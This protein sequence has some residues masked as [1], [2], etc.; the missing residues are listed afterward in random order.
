[1]KSDNIDLPLDT[2]IGD[3]SAKEID[4]LTFEL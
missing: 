4:P 1:M 2:E 3:E